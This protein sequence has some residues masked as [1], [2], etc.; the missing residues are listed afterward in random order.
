MTVVMRKSTSIPMSSPPVRRSEKISPGHLDRVAM[1]YVRQSTA[2][3]VLEN[4]ESTRMQYQL[5]ERAQDLGWA[6]FL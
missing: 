2:R 1:V 5:K 3:Q 6:L 4:H